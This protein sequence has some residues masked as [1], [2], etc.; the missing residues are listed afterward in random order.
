[1]IEYE[2]LIYECEYCK[3]YFKHK[4]HCRRHEKYCKKNPQNKHKCFE[5]CKHLR[6]D[7]DRDNGNTS[8]TCDKK[9]ISLYS[10]KAERMNHDAL[11]DGE[12][13]R[14]PLSCDDHENIYPSVEP[15]EEYRP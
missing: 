7:V 13:V 8:F 6:K 4:W 12:S 11:Y 1:M 10:Y 2:T 3:K 5:F 14:M 9:D 15:M